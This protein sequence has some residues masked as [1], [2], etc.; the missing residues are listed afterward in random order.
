MIKMI[1]DKLDDLL[2]G[3]SPIEE[4]HSTSKE[5]KPVFNVR[6]E[7]ALWIREQFPDLKTYAKKR[8]VYQDLESRKEEIYQAA[9]GAVNHGVLSTEACATAGLRYGWNKFEEGFGTTGNPNNRARSLEAFVSSLEK[10]SISLGGDK[11]H[12]EAGRYLDGA[13]YGRFS[14]GN[15]NAFVYRIGDENGTSTRYL[16]FNERQKFDGKNNYILIGELTRLTKQDVKYL[17]H[18]VKKF[19]G[20]ET[21][22]I[23][24]IDRVI[25][26]DGCRTAYANQSYYSG[27][28]GRRE[29]FDRYD[30][31]DRYDNFD[32]RNESKPARYDA[33]KKNNDFD[34]TMAYVNPIGG[35]NE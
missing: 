30:L 26:V 14:F 18:V 12:T 31:F 17:K 10:L 22:F 6:E 25:P 29:H 9:L 11:H 21:T 13:G 34:A 35:K 5:F 24:Q 4:M 28:F 19:K 15:L 32:I 8:R 33:V 3:E 20:P 27:L 23:E 16:V 2:L 7:F 1:N